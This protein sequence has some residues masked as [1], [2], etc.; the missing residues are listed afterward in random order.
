MA[1][2]GKKENE[3][4]FNKVN[5]PNLLL[6]SY[7]ILLRRLNNL[8]ASYRREL[9]S[10]KALNAG[11][12]SAGMTILAYLITIPLIE[13]GFGNIDVNK[14]GSEDVLIGAPDFKVLVDLKVI[15]VGCVY[16]YT[17]SSS[18]YSDSPDKQIC[19]QIPNGKFGSSLAKAGDMDKDGYD[20]FLA[21]SPDFSDINDDSG[22]EQ[23]G[24]VFLFFGAAKD[25]N[26]PN[27]RS[28]VD[29]IFGGKADTDFG[30]AISSIGDVNGDNQL[31]II[32]GAPDYKVGGIRPGRAMAYFAGIP[33]IPDYEIFTV[34]LPNV[35][36]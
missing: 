29:S 22:E 5:T 35:L 10:R 23:Q 8:K 4:Q 20:D 27:V 6:I 17:G 15:S 16:L 1:F 18:G 25:S 36:K 12:S 32:V 7:S 21:G 34:F 33:G 2:S 11:S 31:D 14:D 28:D 3:L 26:P 19:G 24:A 9:E 30:I 13:G